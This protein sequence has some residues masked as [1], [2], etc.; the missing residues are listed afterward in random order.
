[1]LLREKALNEQD[2]I[3]AQRAKENIVALFKT[4]D[5]EVIQKLEARNIFIR[6]L[7]AYDMDRVIEDKEY[8]SRFIEE[9]KFILSQIKDL[10]ESERRS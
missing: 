9:F 2:K 4:I 5:E 7:L 10:L 1:M 3:K 6:S 8:N